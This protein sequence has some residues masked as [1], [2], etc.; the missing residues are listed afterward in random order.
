M[1]QLKCS[2]ER[3]YKPT[4]D[5][6][7]L[8]KEDRV[9]KKIIHEKDGT[10]VFTIISSIDIFKPL[11]SQ[12]ER[13]WPCA[14]DPC[15]FQPGHIRSIEHGIQFARDNVFRWR[16]YKVIGTKGDR[17]VRQGGGDTRIES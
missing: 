10:K 5:G 2:R 13:T 1:G 17:E 9:S 12:A 6:F 4:Y 8:K 14:G 11:L 16:D 7:P 15:P 3:K